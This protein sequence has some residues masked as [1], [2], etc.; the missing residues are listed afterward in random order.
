MLKR[1]SIPVCVTRSFMGQY[2][3]YD[4]RHNYL[5]TAS[6]AVQEGWYFMDSQGELSKVKVP[7]RKSS[8]DFVFILIFVVIL[9]ILSMAG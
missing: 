5:G 3:I 9:L 8:G 1:E 7:A 6:Q 4:E 2:R